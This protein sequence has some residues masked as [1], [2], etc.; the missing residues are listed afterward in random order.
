MAVR[1]AE[2][3]QHKARIPK[4]MAPV[5]IEHRQNIGDVYP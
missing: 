1:Y 2:H 5:N 4:N 3:T